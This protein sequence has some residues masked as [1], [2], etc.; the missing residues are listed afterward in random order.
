MTVLVTRCCDRLSA[1]IFDGFWIHLLTSFVRGLEKNCE[2]GVADMYVALE[3]LFS[4]YEVA[5][6]LLCGCCV[7]AIWL[8]FVLYLV[9]LWLLSGCYLVA[10]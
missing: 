2:A 8:L 6:W 7:V 9:A 5:I 10:I 3:R 1:S 4:C